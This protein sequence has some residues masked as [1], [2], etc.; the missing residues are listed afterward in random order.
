MSRPLRLEFDGAVY[1]ITSRGDWREDIFDD[2]DDQLMRL[3]VLA[4]H[5]SRSTRRFLR[6]A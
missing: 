2:D 4:R 5:W 6:G 3:E 1:H